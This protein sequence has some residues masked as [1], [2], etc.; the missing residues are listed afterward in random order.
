MSM[1]ALRIV[2]NIEDAEDAVQETFTKAWHTFE[3]SNEIV[4]ARAYLY[5][6]LRNECI[7]H[8]RR[9]PNFES[10]DTIADISEEI[11]DTS[12]RDAAVWRAIDAL[13]KQCRT[14]FLMSKRDGM[15]NA[16]IASELGLSEKTVK[17]QMTKA[18]S[19]LRKALAGNKKVFFL[20]FL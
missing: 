5:R 15:T 14:I 19:R 4:N 9:S 20:P 10:V 8:V 13:P 7:D 16:Q 6:V 12:V 11:I 2:G 18:F 3:S 1:Y 17:N